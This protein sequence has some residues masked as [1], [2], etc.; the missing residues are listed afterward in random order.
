MKDFE[1]TYSATELAKLLDLSIARIGQLWKE[2]VITRE[3]N[4][5]YKLNAVTEYL[6]WYRTKTTGQ[7]GKADKET[8]H[9]RVLK[10]QADKLE[11]ENA[12]AEKE[13]AP[14]AYLEAAL[15]DVLAQMVAL[16]ES[17]PMNLKRSNPKL[18][19]RDIH[20]VKKEL[21]TIRNLAAD[22]NIEDQF[23]AGV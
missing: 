1:E 14:V 2:G 23:E 3:E 9:T 17:L 19:A 21:A 10:A 5:R 7:T 8:E 4:R 11:R 15:A 20:M 22:V 18:T 13:L 6:R 16:F 12:I